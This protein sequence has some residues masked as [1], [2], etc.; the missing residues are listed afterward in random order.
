[1]P[2]HGT[3]GAGVATG[4]WVANDGVRRAGV[5]GEQLAAAL[6]DQ[7]AETS[8][9]TVIH[10]VMV[11]HQRYTF[12]VDHVVV[13][14]RTVVLVDAKLWRPGFYWTWNGRSHR[15]LQA[16]PF[17]DKRG[18]GLA[19]K[20]VAEFIGRR[21]SVRR[22]I[23]AVF[24]TDRAKKLHLWALT[25]PGAALVPGTRL[26]DQL[27]PHCEEADPQLV[28]MMLSLVQRGHA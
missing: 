1:M 10:D 26:V 24:P 27:P 23:V 2:S 22:P 15:G 4:A 16:F 12:N 13:I 14:G 5:R 17:A 3:A 20:A 21:F 9:A 11:P 19:R 25:V 18:M 8:G 7:W 28:K 6:L